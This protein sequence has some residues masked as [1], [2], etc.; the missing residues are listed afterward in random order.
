M[1]SRD[2]AQ[3]T[4]SAQCPAYRIETE[5]L[6]LRCWQ[7]S[8][9]KALLDAISRSLEHL[10]EWMPWAASEPSSLEDKIALLRRWR[11]AFDH[12]D[13]Y[14]FGIFSPDE[15]EV[16]GGSGL[17]K[18]IGANALEIGYWIRADRINKGLATES[19]AALTK[20]AFAV[21]KVDRVEIHCDPTNVRSASVPRKLGFVQE[22]LLRRR[23]AGTDGAPVDTM[24]WTVFSD[25]LDD[26]PIANARVK[27]YDVVG[28]EIRLD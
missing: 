28:C 5:R 15:K 24:I 27:A 11:A 12:D 14:V 25:Q 23:G 6:V 26:T 21:N 13:D 4:Q 2:S 3:S 16:W 1:T 18:R 19:S 10:Q 20:V 22:A 9:A 8:D 7:P 17:H